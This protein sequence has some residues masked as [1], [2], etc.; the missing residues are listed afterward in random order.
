M[1]TCGVGWCSVV[2]LKRNKR[3][4]DLDAYER[5]RQHSARPNLSVTLLPCPN[6]A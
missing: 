3:K 6:S 5:A 1:I 2:V 4:R